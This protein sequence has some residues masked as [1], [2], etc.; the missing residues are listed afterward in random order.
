M[1]VDRDAAGGHLLAEL[2]GDHGPVAVFGG[3]Q[4]LD[5]HRDPQIYGAFSRGTFSSRTGEGDRGVRFHQ[6]ES[7]TAVAMRSPPAP[8]NQAARSRRLWMMVKVPG[9]LARAPWSWP[10]SWAR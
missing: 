1:D 6:S 8:A 5:L 10:A 3:V 2:F 7:A 4:V 9:R